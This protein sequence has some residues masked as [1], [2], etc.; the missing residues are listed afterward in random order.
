MANTKD[1][2]RT[3]T[4]DQ[5][6]TARESQ[7][8][9]HKG[10]IP[11]NTTVT[12]KGNKA[13]S[14]SPLRLFCC[15]PKGEAYTDQPA[16]KKAAELEARARAWVACN[17]HIWAIWVRKV[18]AATNTG[19]RW[20]IQ[21]LAEQARTLDTVN[22]CGEPFRVNNTLLP[23]LARILCEEVSEARRF[24]EVRTSVFEQAYAERHKKVS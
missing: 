16:N 20:S 11:K 22:D 21:S 19:Q 23:A 18:K 9:T 14:A 8:A 5:T 12:P 2:P 15:L 6:S 4:S 1:D 24:V 13:R 3:V 7:N 10:D 17:S